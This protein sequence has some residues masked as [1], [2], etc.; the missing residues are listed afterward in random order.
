MTNELKISFE[1][2]RRTAVPQIGARRKV[3]VN[4]RPETLYVRHVD[5]SAYKVFTDTGKIVKLYKGT[6]TLGDNDSLFG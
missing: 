5:V 6:A 2:H 3:Q 4:G 1:V